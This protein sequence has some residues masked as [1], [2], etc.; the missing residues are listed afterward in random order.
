MPRSD[1]VFGTYTSQSLLG[2]VRNR[3]KH[4]FTFVTL[5]GSMVSVMPMMG[6]PPAEVW[7]PEECVSE[8]VDSRLSKVKGVA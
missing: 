4:Y 3:R 5:H 7:R 2:N 1:L 6:D 8:L